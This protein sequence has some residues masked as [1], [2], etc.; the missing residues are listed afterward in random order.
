VI[1]PNRLSVPGER[2]ALERVEAIAERVDALDIGRLA[3]SP[4]LLLDPDERRPLVAEVE[5]EA[6]RCGRR[7][8]LDE[9]CGR[10]GDALHA[11]LG[12]PVRFDPVGGYPA[13]PYRADDAALVVTAVIDAV[14]VAVMEDRVAPATAARLAGPGRALLGLPPLD[15]PDPASGGRPLAEPSAADWAEA[16]DGDT[17]IDRYSPIPI[18]ARV[19]FA[20]IAALVL[21]PAAV[22]A[23][24]VQGQTGAGVLAGLAIVAVCWLV[25]TY[26][27]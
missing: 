8:L 16:V 9:V 19:A 22:F 15:G 10:V 7:P 20:I 11:R 12:R 24:A 18:G 3:P 26:R 25:A 14:A 4:M 23:G 21:A 5:A 13:T 17:R 2:S 6:D 27:R 1:E